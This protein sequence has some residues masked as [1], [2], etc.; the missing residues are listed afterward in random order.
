PPQHTAATPASN[1]PTPPTPVLALTAGSP[2]AAGDP[3]ASIVSA[4]N[5]ARVLEQIKPV[6]NF[7]GTAALW[8]NRYFSN[9][10]ANVPAGDCAIHLLD[11]WASA[12]AL[13]KVEGHDA[14]Y[15]RAT[16]IAGL[17]MTFAQV[18][19]LDSKSSSGQQRIAEWL[20]RLA[21]D[22]RNFYDALPPTSTV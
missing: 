21:L 14:E 20:H 16:I 19:G 15:R 10:K 9:P 17:S 3:T 8:A 13:S 7:A 6:W 18:Q 22:M 11:A 12:N 1:C 2:Y 4:D 5:E